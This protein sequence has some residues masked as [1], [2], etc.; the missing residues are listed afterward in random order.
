MT[1]AGPHQAL[2]FLNQILWLHVRGQFL[3]ILLYLERIER[4]KFFR[5]PK[6]VYTFIPMLQNELG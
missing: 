1:K 3:S 6:Q 2:P 4:L 5:L